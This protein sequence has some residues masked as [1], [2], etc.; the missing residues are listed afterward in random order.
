MGVAMNIRNIATIAFAL[1]FGL[2]AVLLT[3]FWL[4]RQRVADRQTA[5]IEGTTPVVVAAQPIARGMALEPS[6]LK[7]VRF[8]QG[9]VPAGAL[10]SVEQATVGGQRLVLRPI[11]ANEPILSTKITTP[12]GKVNLSAAMTAGMRAVTFRS[13]DVAGVAGF[14]LPGDRVDVL[15]TRDAAA[16]SENS[17]LLAQVVADNL[18]VLAIDQVDDDAAGKPVVA[19]AITLEVTPDQAQTI[20]LAQAA[21]TVSLALRQVGDVEPVGRRMTTVAD[22]G[23]YRSSSP[24]S[25]PV[26]TRKVVA[27]S[28]R[29]AA[30]SGPRVVVTRGVES[31]AYTLLR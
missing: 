23:G 16:G 4:G 14:V 20:A 25:R 19:K 7:V 22:L 28:Y 26:T 18:K 8:P 6:L 31:T 13:N 27:T 2:V 11:A 5:A 17:A 10:S 21:G 29:P 30:P 9:S 12:G 24:V 1:L 3:Q 15:L